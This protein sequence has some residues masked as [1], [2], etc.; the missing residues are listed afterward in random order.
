MSLAFSSYSPA[1]D[2]VLDDLPNHVTALLDEGARPA[3]GPGGDAA[4]LLFGL[5]MIVIHYW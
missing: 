5:V 4:S 3:N 1:G 2:A